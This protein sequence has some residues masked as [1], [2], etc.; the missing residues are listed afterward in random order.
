MSAF[1]GR[2]VSDPRRPHRIKRRSWSLPQGVHQVSGSSRS[3]SR[4]C[5]SEYRQPVARRLERAVPFGTSPVSEASAGGERLADRPKRTAWWPG[6]VPSVDRS[7]DVAPAAKCH[8]HQMSSRHR[9]AHRVDHL[10]D[11]LPLL[12]KCAV[13][14]S[15]RNRAHTVLITSVMVRRINAYSPRP[16]P[17]TG[18]GCVRRPTVSPDAPGSSSPR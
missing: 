2:R 12:D 15:R 6:A 4:A 16:G 9:R 14:F 3:I 11:V 1:A 17:A 13:V 7:V 18:L 5:R 10:H 8:E